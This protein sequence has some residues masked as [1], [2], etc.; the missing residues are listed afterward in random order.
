[1][2]KI[3]REYMKDKLVINGKEFDYN[4][5]DDLKQI[6]AENFA[7]QITRTTGGNAE[8]PFICTE[9]VGHMS[10]PWDHEAKAAGARLLNASYGEAFIWADGLVLMSLASYY[11]SARTFVSAWV[12]AHEME[13]K[14]LG[15]CYNGYTCKKCGYHYTVDSS[16]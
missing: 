1:M 12:C 6:T 7:S 10:F 3:N 15:R 5:L 8:I 11:G 2:Y 13:G 16:D 4:T 9:R 14:N